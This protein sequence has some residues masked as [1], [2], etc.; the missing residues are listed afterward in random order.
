M[1][2]REYDEIVNLIFD[3]RDLS[4]A[5]S[6]LESHLNNGIPD[7]HFLN[8]HFSI[9]PMSRKEF[10]RRKSEGLKDLALKG[11]AR[12]MYALAIVYLHG[13]EEETADKYKHLAYLSA[14][15]L[16]WDSR[17]LSELKDL[18]KRDLG[19]EIT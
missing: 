1:R 3:K 10:D 2:K 4:S 7:A 11:H 14:A 16:S 19:L 9:T 18:L 5:S 13:D 15:A 8:L 12:S 17:A 6:R